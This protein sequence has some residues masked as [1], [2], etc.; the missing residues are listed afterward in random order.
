MCGRAWRWNQFGVTAMA[1]VGARGAGFA[2]V[3]ERHERT[4]G[5]AVHGGE[6]SLAHRRDDTRVFVPAD[7]EPGLRRLDRHGTFPDASAVDLPPAVEDIASESPRGLSLTDVARGPAWLFVTGAAA[8]AALAAVG[9]PIDLLPAELWALRPLVLATNVASL[10]LGAAV[11]GRRPDAWTANRPLA[12]AVV[13]MAAGVLVGTLESVAFS[14]AWGAGLLL[15]GPPSHIG[16]ALIALGYLGTAL[17]VVGIALIWLTLH[18]SLG[19]GVSRGSRRLAVAMWSLAVLSAI[20]R[21]ASTAQTIELFGISMATANMGIGSVLGIASVVAMTALTLTAV[22]GARS[23]RR[24]RSAWW[25]VVASGLFATVGEWLA[26]VFIAVI[27]PPLAFAVSLPQ[28]VGL[29]STLLLLWALALGLPSTHG[30][31]PRQGAAEP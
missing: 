29:T 24:P 15:P 18:R 5:S 13:L 21:L 16:W 23:E 6:P 27:N 10:L 25:L 28:A 20:G 31:A 7:F 30:D 14:V 3:L 1:M 4:G 11:F 2:I 12:A 26:G 17:N 9:L 22:D 8:I 19:P